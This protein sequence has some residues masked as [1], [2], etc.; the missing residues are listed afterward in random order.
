M[1]VLGLSQTWE[2]K[3]A[4]VYSLSSGGQNSEIKVSAELVPLEGAF[5]H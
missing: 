5:V 1:S 2:L 3:T 4:E